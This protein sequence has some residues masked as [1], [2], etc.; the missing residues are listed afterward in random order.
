MDELNSDKCLLKMNNICKSFPTVKALDDVSFDLYPGEI[1]CLVGENGAG[2][3]TFIKILSG[4]LEHDSGE[5]FFSGKK[6]DHLTPF[7]SQNLGIRTIYQEAVLIPNLSVTENIFIGGELTSTFGFM[8]FKKEREETLKLLNELNIELDPD[9]LVE[10]LDIA[11]R[12]TVQIA[13]ALAKKAKILI[14]D[15]PT[16]SLGKNETENLLKLMRQI[17]AKGVGIIYI[18]H[19]LEEVFEIGDKVT[20]LR[21]GQ[22]VAH[23]DVKNV[24]SNQVIINEM[25]GRDVSMFYKKQPHEIGE[26]VLEVRDYCSKDTSAS[27]SFKLRKGEILSI[28]GM[29]GSGRTELLRQL[30]A[31]DKRIKGQMLLDGKDITPSSPI[32]AIKNGLCMIPEDRQRSGLFLDRSIKDNII[33]SALK[34]IKY[35]FFNFKEEKRIPQHYMHLLK[36]KANSSEQLVRSLSGG[37]QQ[38]VVLSKWLFANARIFLFDE[39]TRGVDIGVKEEMYNIMTNLVNNGNSIIM[40]SSDLPEVI[41]MSDRVL[42]MKTGKIVGELLADKITEQKIIFYSIGGEVQI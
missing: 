32:E 9:E 15:E 6:Y 34:K 33:I 3:S 38:K 13:K 23:H 22:K 10:K 21:D 7:I 39:P 27:I 31:I 35:F 1:H 41:A 37:N 40:V 36:I 12:Q 19:H 5:I 28:V 8:K 17:K 42:V 16:A 20:V 24:E 18:S 14:L 29:V 4:A 30:F 26:V 11:S 2:K 25:V